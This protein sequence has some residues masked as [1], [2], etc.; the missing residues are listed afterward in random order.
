MVGNPPTTRKVIDKGKN[1]YPRIQRS[2]LPA[3][4]QAEAQRNPET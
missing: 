2:L 3:S 4:D 1:K